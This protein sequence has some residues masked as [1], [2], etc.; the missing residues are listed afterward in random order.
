MIGRRVS[1]KG[2]TW[3][4]ASLVMCL[5]AEAAQAACPPAPRQGC[6]IGRV[7]VL[8]IGDRFDDRFD[9]INFDLRY[10]ERTELVEFGDP[11]G[12]DDYQLCV[13]GNGNLA[14]EVLIPSG[15]EWTA[16]ATSYSHKGGHVG[17]DG[18][19]YAG[20]RAGAHERSRVWMR[21]GGPDVPAIALPLAEPV[22][23]QLQNDASPLCFE[24]SFAGPD[25]V[26]ENS[27]TR[28]TFRGSSRLD[29][30][31]TPTPTPEGPPVPTPTPT[32]APQRYEIEAVRDAEPLHYVPEVAQVSV[33]EFTVGDGRGG[34]LYL[35]HQVEMRAQ[36]DVLAE[37]F[38]AMV[39]YG[40]QD[41][42]G[43]FCVIDHISLEHLTAMYDAADRA[44]AIAGLREDTTTV[45]PSLEDC[46]DGQVCPAGEEC[47]IFEERVPTGTSSFVP[48]TDIGNVVP[49]VPEEGPAPDAIEY[50][51]QQNFKC[52]TQAYAAAQVAKA[53]SV[54][55]QLS[56]ADLAG[57]VQQRHAIGATTTLP[58]SCAS[59]IG[60]GDVTAWVAFDPEFDTNFIA[61]PEYDPNEP[62]QEEPDLDEDIQRL[63][64]E[65]RAHRQALPET[66]PVADVLP[67]PGLNAE[68]RHLRVGSSVVLID[69]EEAPGGDFH[70]GADYSFDG[71]PSP[72]QAEALGAPD[73]S[74]AFTMRPVGKARA[75]CTP[76]NPLPSMTAVPLDII[77]GEGGEEAPPF[78]VGTPLD[79]SLPLH[80]PPALREKVFTDWACWDQYEI[81]GCLTTNIPQDPE[82]GTEDDCAY[83]SVIVGRNAQPEDAETVAAPAPLLFSRVP[84]LGSAGCSD[85]L[86]KAY[87]EN[88]KKHHELENSVHIDD[89]YVFNYLDWVWGSLS[90]PGAGNGFTYITNAARQQAYYNHIK[91]YLTECEELGGQSC[92]KAWGAKHSPWN[93]DIR[94]YTEHTVPYFWNQWDPT[95]GSYPSFKKNPQLGTR[96]GFNFECEGIYN[97]SVCSFINYDLTRVPQLATAIRDVLTKNQTSNPLMAKISPHGIH[98]CVSRGWYALERY[99]I[100][101]RGKVETIPDDDI[102]YTE[103]LAKVCAKGKYKAAADLIWKQIASSCTYVAKPFADSGA[104][105]YAGRFVPE[106]YKTYDTGFKSGL[107][108]VVEGGIVNDYIV[109]TAMK[110]FK[111][112]FGAQGRI[113]LESD[114]NNDVVGGINVHDIFKTWML[115]NFYS[116][117]LSSNVEAGFHVLTHDI[118]KISFK[119]PTGEFELPNPPELSK[120][121]EKCK[122]LWKFPMPFRIELCGSVG[123]KLDLQVGAKILKNGIEGVDPNKSD[124]PGISGTITPGAAVF[125]KGRAGV[126]VLIASAGLVLTI[127]P[128]IGVFIPIE[129]GAKWDLSMPTFR[130]LDFTLSPYVKTTLELKA[131]GGQ[132]SGYT[133]WKI[134]NT[135]EDEYPIPG[136]KWDPLDIG[137]LAGQEWVL[138]KHSWDISGSKNF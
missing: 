33:L 9:R 128:T 10:A 127:D 15:P 105:I 91:A 54:P 78:A 71:E 109:A 2:G 89:Y 37:P 129:V 80:L 68:F 30:L 95:K 134:G 135:S 70:V 5:A 136:A 60:A 4:L 76:P 12:S 28:R 63:L 83:T 131:L 17:A 86:F 34:P 53:K 81:E 19:T 121:V 84:R 73:V 25:Q 29:P 24:A 21:A 98:R 1:W 64:Q 3:L 52:T 41:E 45:T 122:H 113:Y 79:V 67:D 38:K 107:K 51:L 43:D 20:L 104:G 66:V 39:W 97:G 110:Q 7:G 23:A 55:K 82:I 125:N 35:G 94:N 138:V 114:P 132:M 48:D 46:S 111:L 106:L 119:I 72:S 56:P 11:I 85:T 61:R 57:S 42:D 13:Y 74:F 32:R 124:W 31:P 6:R 116:D 130:Q 117:I 88:M 50:E 40:L 65:L 115:G 123:G 18:L 112:I 90:Y 92:Y 103:Y 22:V 77:Y 62:L 36:L 108:G 58:D 49:Q 100:D 87:A 8:R 75:G 69:P 133:R 99:K 101:D 137:N 16:E 96:S 59:L 126:D 102:F 27:Q 118:W 120:E 93:I 44:N 26:L 47:A 14:G